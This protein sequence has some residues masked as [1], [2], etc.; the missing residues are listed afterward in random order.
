MFTRQILTLKIKN[1]RSI[2]FLKKGII[3]KTITIL[4]L[5]FY[6]IMNIFEYP[7]IVTIWTGCV[8][9]F[10]FKNALREA[11]ELWSTIIFSRVL[12]KLL[13]ITLILSRL[14]LLSASPLSAFKSLSSSTLASSV[15]VSVCNSKFVILIFSCKPLKSF[16]ICAEV[17]LSP[18]GLVKSI[19]T[20]I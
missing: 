1:Y 15:L 20:L 6:G 19:W 14:V 8:R 17:T 7:D 18:L 3:V 9:L 13:F 16:L 5:H 10:I 2:K 4:Y 11:P 12:N